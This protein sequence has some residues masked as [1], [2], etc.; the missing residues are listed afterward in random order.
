MSNHSFFRVLKKLE[1]QTFKDLDE[2]LAFCDMDFT[3][4][5]RDLFHKSKLTP[6]VL[7]GQP[8]DSAIVRT[9]NEV[10]VG[11]GSTIYGVVQYRN[12]FSLCE[13]LLGM[14]GVTPIYG[15]APNLGERA[16]LAF[17]SEGEISLG[18]DKKITNHFF[19]MSSHDGSSKVSVTSAPIA[20]G[21]L[22]L[23]V[24]AP[25]LAI[26]H[27]KKANDKVSAAKLV[28]DKTASKWFEFEDSV[29]KLMN[30]RVTDDEAH[31]FIKSVVGEN[32]S[33]RSQNIRDKIYDI[34][35]HGIARMFPNCHGTLFGLVLA[36]VEW[37]DNHQTVRESK[38][39]DEDTAALTAKLTGAGATNKAKAWGV[40]LTMQRNKNKLKVSNA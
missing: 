31:M 33:T 2:L 13:P 27:S 19:V 39:C 22:V 9:E 28:M 35:K 15:G 40:A 38:Y 30:V 25:V 16:Y 36:C 24:E 14:K 5:L 32:D 34:S 8:F 17:R 11:T 10:C 23:N 12:S 3:V 20:S 29:R 26:K 7:L 37:A 1:G 4:E 6:G 21:G 18:N